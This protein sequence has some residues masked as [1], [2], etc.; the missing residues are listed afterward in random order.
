[1][2]ESGILKIVIDYNTKDASYRFQMEENGI[3]VDVPS[4]VILG[5]LEDVK[6][7]IG[8]SAPEI[9]DNF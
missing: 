9:Q 4:Y 6:M 3:P 5:I 7:S 8:M 1:M 2:N